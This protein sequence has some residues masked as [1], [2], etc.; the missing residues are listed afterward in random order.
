MKSIKL[1]KEIRKVTHGAVDQLTNEQ[2]TTIPKGYKNNILWNIGHV[3]VTQ[4]L[5]H[6]KFS[7]LD[8]YVSKDLCDKFQR[9]TSPSDW[10]SPPDVEQIKS[11]LLELPGNLE[12]DYNAGKFVSFNEYTTVTGITLNDFDDSL[13]FNNFHEGVHLGITMA[14]RKLVS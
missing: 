10:F 6:Y 5:L 2:L 9:G 11:S 12:D 1:L 3:V 13:L 4:Q 7:G 8:M 14:M